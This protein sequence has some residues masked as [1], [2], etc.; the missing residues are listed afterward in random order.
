[1]DGHELAERVAAQIRKLPQDRESL[2]KAV[3]SAFSAQELLGERLDQL[4]GSV[5]HCILWRTQYAARRHED[6]FH[7]RTVA[8]AAARALLAWERDLLDAG[9]QD[10]VLGTR[11]HVL[12]TRA[13]K[14]WSADVTEQD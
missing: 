6:G 2:M 5:A 7:G 1:M 13:E 9:Q 10:L 12:V 4:L 11:L 14:G 8:A 3:V